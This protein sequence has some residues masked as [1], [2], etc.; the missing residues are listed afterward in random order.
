MLYIYNVISFN[1]GSKHVLVQV[2][3]IDE[4][5]N[6]SWKSVAQTTD[7]ELIQAKGA[8]E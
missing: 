1:W 4:L 8:Y 2:K 5:F 7:L 6:S 3:L